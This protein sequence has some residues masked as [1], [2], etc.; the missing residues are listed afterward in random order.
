MEKFIGEP[1]DFRL[2]PDL[3]N[4]DPE[5]AH[6]HFFD[7]IRR[8]VMRNCEDDHFINDQIVKLQSLNVVNAES[9]VT[10]WELAGKSRGNP[11]KLTDICEKVLHEKKTV[12]L[13]G[14]FAGEVLYTK[15]ANGKGHQFDLDGNLQMLSVADKCE[16]IGALEQ[17]HRLDIRQMRRRKFSILT[18]DF[19]KRY[20]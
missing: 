17:M 11:F 18:Q 10:M 7:K 9:V 6:Y 14:E 13:S 15:L 2:E 5:S 19:G 20:T 12:F 3:S 1:T 4:I 16:L 8:S